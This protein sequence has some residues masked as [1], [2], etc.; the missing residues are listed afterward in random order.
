MTGS[1]RLNT[2][3]KIVTIVIG[4]TLDWSI[5]YEQAIKLESLT[6]YS[7]YLAIVATVGPEG[8]QEG[9]IIG[10]HCTD[11]LA[12]IGL[13]LPLYKSTEIVLDGDG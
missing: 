2:G 11:D 3:Y 4:Y 8:H 6:E 5:F 13:I 12:H 10:F 1:R 9:V 7:K